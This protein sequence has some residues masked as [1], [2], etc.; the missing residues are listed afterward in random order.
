MSITPSS[1]CIRV[2]GVSTSIDQA[3]RERDQRGGEVAAVDRRDVARVERRQRRR[4]VPVEEV[5]FMPLEAF[6]RR[7]RAI[8]TSNQ[9][10][11]RHVAEIVRGQRRQQRH[12]DVGRRGAPGQPRLVTFLIVV[13]RQPRVRFRDECLVVAPGLACRPAQ[14]AAARDR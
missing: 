12:A 2:C 7:Q 6:E 5:T 3:L 9:R 8:E 4:V 1:R 10:R 11:G 13:R 14:Q